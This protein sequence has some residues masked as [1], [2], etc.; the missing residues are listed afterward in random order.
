[1]YCRVKLVS[2]CEGIVMTPVVSRPNFS[3]SP[4]AVRKY[5]RGYDVLLETW[6]CKA[7]GFVKLWMVA[8]F[9]V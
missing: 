6:I 1:M 5:F 8:F 9:T 7:H 4:N 2:E 3:E